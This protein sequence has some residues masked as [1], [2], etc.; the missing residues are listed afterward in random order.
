MTNSEPTLHTIEDVL[1]ELDR[2]IEDAVQSND[3]L[4]VFA[5]IYWRTTQRIQEGIVQGEFA[6]AEKM[7]RFDVA[8]AKRYIDAYWQFKNGQTPTQS[9]LTSFHAR[10]QKLT[11]MQ[12][13]LMGMNAHIN[14][15]LGIVAA[16]AAP[17]EKIQEIEAD[18]MKVNKLLASLTDEMQER[19]GRV[20]IF[21]MWLDKIGGNKDELAANLGIMLSRE[22]AWF[23]ARQLA[24][25][26]PEEQVKYIQKV[27]SDIA[28]LSRTIQEPPG[29]LL[30]FLLRIISWFEEKNVQK[31][32]DN[33]RK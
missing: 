5:F 21:V 20:S 2:I 30:K 33:L 26:N 18:F 25:R 13:L 31:I 15:D 29:K 16:E 7:E 27:D 9:W 8:F 17:G 22:Y 11:L 23:V 24:M 12:H 10:L 3:Y 19:M 28:R 14:L 1:N 4:G 6:N 32:I